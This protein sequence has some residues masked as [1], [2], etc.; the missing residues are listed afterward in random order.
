MSERNRGIDLF[1]IVAMIFAVGVHIVGQGGILDA[2][3][4]Q[5]LGYE[6]ARILDILFVCCVDCF[7][8]ISGYVGYGS[9]FKPANIL[10]LWMETLFYSVLITVVFHFMIRGSIYCLSC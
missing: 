4:K 7:A 8:L 9:K 5:S 6:T 1:R 2:S 10:Y 3:V